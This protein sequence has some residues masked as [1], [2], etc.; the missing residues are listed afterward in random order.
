MKYISL[1]DNKTKSAFTIA[2]EIVTS[3]NRKYEF[4]AGLPYMGDSFGV[5]SKHE[6][7]L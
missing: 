1:K 4:L 2:L 3:S 7:S 6:V 5:I